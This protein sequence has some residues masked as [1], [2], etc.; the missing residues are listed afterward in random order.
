MSS[1]HISTFS[2]NTSIVLWYSRSNKENSQVSLEDSNWST[3]S[4][5]PED[6]KVHQHQCDKRKSRVNPMFGARQLPWSLNYRGAD[7][8]VAWPTS[9]CILFD[10]EN[11]SFGASLVNNSFYSF[12][13]IYRLLFNIV[14]TW[15][16]PVKVETY[17]FNCRIY[18]LFWTSCVSD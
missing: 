1:C 6:W 18:H 9:R 8:S 11:I 10:G 5:V 7:K 16:W 14:E 4:H 3:L 12:Y 2:I 15:R 13:S 17:S